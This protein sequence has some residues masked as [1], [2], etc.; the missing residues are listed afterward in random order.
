MELISAMASYGMNRYPLSGFPKKLDIEAV[1]KELKIQFP[2]DRRCEDLQ[3]TEMAAVDL[4]NMV[5]PKSVQIHFSD[6]S[7]SVMYQEA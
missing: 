4:G 6:W 7:V 1:K 5:V 3:V 2:D